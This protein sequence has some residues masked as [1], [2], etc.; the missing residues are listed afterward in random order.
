M[1]SLLGGLGLLAAFAALVVGMQAALWAILTLRA[2]SSLH[3]DAL[4]GALH[5]PLSYLLSTERGRLLSRFSR[6]LDA[7]DAALPALLAQ[8]LTCV[9]ALAAALVAILTSSP[10]A[11]PLVALLGGAFGHIVVRYRPT[12]A[13]AKRLVSVLHGPTVS[14][15]LDVL[16]VSAA[17][18]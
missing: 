3:T 5:A 4:R 15:L 9:A 8:A 2:S 11:T 17:P 12:A 7:L 1:P 14:H 6:D 16:E 18:R 13:D 10:L